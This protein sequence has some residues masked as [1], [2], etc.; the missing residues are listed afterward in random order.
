MTDAPDPRGNPPPEDRSPPGPR[1]ALLWGTLLVALIFGAVQGIGLLLGPPPGPALPV[2]PVP[3]E[4]PG[5]QP[6]RGPDVVEVVVGAPAP[7][8]PPESAETPRLPATPGREA[9]PAP[10]PETA[11][12]PPPGV[13]GP[14]TAPESA[15]ASSEGPA[16]PPAAASRPAPAEVV[17]QAPPVGAVVDEPAAPP[18]PPATAAEAP[19][20]DYVLQLG[21]FRS[22]RYRREAEETAARLGLPYFREERSRP[23]PSFRLQVRSTGPEAASRAAALLDS[24]GYLYR[25]TPGGLEAR[26]ALEEEA[27]EA[28]DL[29]AREGSEATYSEEKGSLFWMVYA[30]PFSEADARAVR[31]R[32]AGEGVESFLRRRR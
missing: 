2:A 31:E 10:S 13:S 7:V 32:L 18:S 16:Q 27:R 22:Q 21:A 19:A 11:A 30:G 15:A 29:L 26:F 3:P 12:E 5:T 24:A 28:A 14:A 9:P 25:E 1:P 17:G 23:G 6:R 8:A 4:G 20:G